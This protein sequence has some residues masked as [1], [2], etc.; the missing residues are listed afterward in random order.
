M[1]AVGAQ[2]RWITR[3]HPMD[4]G[5]GPGSPLDKLV[6]LNGQVLLLG[7]PLD[8]I[9]LLHYAENRAQ[10]RA[11][12]VIRYSCPV[13]RDGKTVWIDVED[14]NTGEPHDA[15]TFEG[16]AQAYLAQGKGHHGRVGNAPSY[17]FEAADLTAFA[18]RWLEERF[19]LRV[20]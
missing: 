13:L 18:I 12:Q 4:Y 1:V 5:Y 8:T 14:F 19:G 10:L 6:G 11:K 17:L 9:T 20:P 15:Y 16:I 3:D 7:A 2:A